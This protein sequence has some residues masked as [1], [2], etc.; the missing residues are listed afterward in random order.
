MPEALTELEEHIHESVASVDVAVKLMT[1]EEFEHRLEIVA[2]VSA[3]V[4][5]RCPTSEIGRFLT[6]FP[7]FEKKN[8]GRLMRSPCC[9]CCPPPPNA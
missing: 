1:W 6:Y 7:Y 2:N 9:L 4:V 3:W 8:K 5:V